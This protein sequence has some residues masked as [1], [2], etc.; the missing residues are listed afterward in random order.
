MLIKGNFVDENTNNF[1]SKLKVNV[2]EV[3][4]E[5]NFLKPA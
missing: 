4:N 5:N 1:L 3:S 2:K